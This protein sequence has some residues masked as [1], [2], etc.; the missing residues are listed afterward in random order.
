[1]TARATPESAVE[2]LEVNEEEVILDVP[3]SIADCDRVIPN[4]AIEF[5]DEAG[6]WFCWDLEE[7]QPRAPH[8]GY[9]GTVQWGRDNVSWDNRPGATYGDVIDTLNA[10]INGYYDESWR[11]GDGEEPRPLYPMLIIP[12]AEFSPDPGLMLVD[13]DSVVKPRS[14]GTAVLTREAWNIIQSFD[15]YAELS[16]SK[17]GVH[18]LVRGQFPEFVDARK[19]IEDL[20]TAGQCELY[21]YPGNG[22]VIGTT[23]AHI[24][25]TPP[26]T[27]HNQDAI[28]GLADRLVDDEEQLSAREQAEQV[29]EEHRNDDDTLTG[30]SSGSG[31]PYYDLNPKQI[32]R[33]G[34]FR[35]HGSNGRGPH[36]EHG[37]TSTPDAESTNF[38]VSRSDGWK[39]WAHN[40]GGGALQLIAVLENIRDCG[41]ARN[42]MDDPVDALRTCL[43]ARDEYTGEL[44]GETP[45]TA[46]LKGVLEVQGIEPRETDD[47]LLP[48]SQYEAAREMYRKMSYTG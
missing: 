21:G 35:T 46:A 30:G 15:A 1:M 12:H 9:A 17:T 48:R 14:D 39:C 34:Q 31:N 29:F 3:E 26:E 28:D 7:K 45:P 36:P 42:V 41:N 13:L 11:W 23:W 22:R 6:A 4:D 33:T 25:A 5:G 27:P 44:D 24:D 18:V 37:G 38:A 20:D 32:A 43:A 19:I 40:D 8:N 16:T 10:R 47:E 2:V